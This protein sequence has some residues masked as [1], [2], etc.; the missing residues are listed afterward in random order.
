MK[1]KFVLSL[2]LVCTMSQE[3]LQ[4]QKLNRSQKDSILHNI[5]IMLEKYYPFADVAEYT[6]TKLKEQISNGFYNIYDRP[7]EFAYQVT[8]NMENFSSDKHL[9]LL[10]NPALAN[11]LLTEDDGDISVYRDGE[12]LTEVWNNYGFKELSILEGN[13]GYLNLSL[14]FATEYAGKTADAAMNFFSNCNALIIDLRQNGGGWDDMVTYLLAYFVDNN[15]PMLMNISQYTIDGSYYSSVIPNIVQGRRLTDIPIYILTSPVTASAA[16][17]FISHLKYLNKNITLVGDR[18]SG[19][20][21]PV[22]HFAIDENFVLQLPCWKKIFSANPFVVERKGI[23]PD[24]KVRN[25]DA[26]RIAH[27]AALEKL[28]S[29]TIE[30]LALEKYQ[31]AL[32]G[33]N[34]SLDNYSPGSIESFQGNYGQI[35]ITSRED[36][37]YCQY[38]N[39]TPKLM[40]PVSDNYFIIEG[41]DFYRIR[42]DTENSE[43]RI[44][45]IFSWGITREA[46][47]E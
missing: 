5:C 21:N 35:T 14:F 28:M 10:Y 30:E 39:N 33:L 46:R 25:E 43:V 41:V 22:D 31:W 34:A 8:V 45:Q 42:F 12:A 17:G 29:D 20:E 24:I 15:E 13:I 38:K 26:K 16:E 11:S 3:I 7:D 27:I 1:F 40:I 6:M 44:V 2:V 18:T 32:D 9:D 47:K 4:A 37:L 23:E 19:A 36:K